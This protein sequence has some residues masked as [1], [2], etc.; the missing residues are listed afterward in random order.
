MK[1]NIIDV[2]GSLN[3]AQCI[4][5]PALGVHQEQVAYLA[6]RLAEK[7]AW[8]Q[9]KRNKMFV[10]GLLH[11]V[12]ALSLQE[13]EMAVSEK[14]ADIH[15]HAFR[16]AYLIQGFLP[17]KNIAPI[18]KYHHILWNYGK[19]ADENPEMPM[20]SQLL[21]LADRV[22]ASLSASPF[23]LNQAS[24]IKKRILLEAGER[25]VP[26]YVDAFMELAD[27]EYIWLDLISKEVVR[28]ID[29]SYF[30]SLEIS[31]DDLTDLARCYSYLIDFRS[32]FTAA[33]SARVAKTAQKLSELLHFS[34]KDS[35]RMLVAGYLH[36]LGKLTVDPAILEKPAALTK[37]EYA[38]I[39]S[40]TY[41]T[42]YLLD[43]I[44]G[45]ETIQQ[46]AAFH[47]ERL[48]GRGY[49]FH[50]REEDLS[51]GSR[52]MAAADVFAALKETRPY[53][54]ALSEE[55]IGSIMKGMAES[56]AL[57]RYIVETLLGNYSLL[58]DICAEAGESAR[59][60]YRVLYSIEA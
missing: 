32:P 28:R 18:V 3:K 38:V 60:E 45:L 51:I 21:H 29:Y 47:H 44:S 25:F 46:W 23:V 6:Y 59:R 24:P 19:A 56:Q 13:K 48:S 22:C 5:S 26:E 8:P 36:D 40:H 42:Y 11:D 30:A 37:E 12:G 54:P 7:L 43:G 39:R 2:L 50:I 20:E 14:G 1:L 16:G 52:I 4:I 17:E 55:K 10:A 31:V 49:P 57:D 9:K 33:H 27:T 35:K 34:S 15:T 41:Y 58:S 53:K